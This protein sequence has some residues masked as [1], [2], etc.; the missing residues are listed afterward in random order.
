[1]GPSKARERER[2]KEREG[3]KTN[4]AF[5]IDGSL[6]EKRELKVIRRST[7]CVSLK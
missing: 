1:M 5:K 3:I 2:E 4:K 7:K 6:E